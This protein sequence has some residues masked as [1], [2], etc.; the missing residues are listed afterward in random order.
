M[1]MDIMDKI[2]NPRVQYLVMDLTCCANVML[3]T[4]IISMDVNNLQGVMILIYHTCTQ[5]VFRWQNL[6][7]RQFGKRKKESKASLREN[8]IK[9]YRKYLQLSGSAHRRKPTVD[10]DTSYEHGQSR[11]KVDFWIAVLK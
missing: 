10:F 1:K 6:C 7:A 2:V 9:Q 11:G 8:H 4:V 3:H 5:D